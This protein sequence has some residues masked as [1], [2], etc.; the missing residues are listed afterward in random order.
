M[1]WYQQFNHDASRLRSVQCFE[2]LL[3]ARR[4]VVLAFTG[5]E[6]IPAGILFLPLAFRQLAALRTA[7]FNGVNPLLASIEVEQQRN[8]RILTMAMKQGNVYFTLF[9]FRENGKIV[10]RQLYSLTV[11]DQFGNTSIVTGKN[12]PNMFVVDTGLKNAT[13]NAGNMAEMLFAPA[14]SPK[15]FPQSKKT[16]AWPNLG[17]FAS[18]VIGFCSLLILRS[19]LDLLGLN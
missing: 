12:M 1:R 11:E 13:D 8:W 15:A 17:D 19:V 2:A 6:R 18:F 4:C 7:V 14:N 5:R 3:Q 10:N 16:K 9:T